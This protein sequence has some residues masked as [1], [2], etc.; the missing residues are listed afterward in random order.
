MIESK[1]MQQGGLVVIGGYYIFHSPM[2]NIISVSIGHTTLN[3]T[4]GKPRAKALTIMIAAARLRI[5]FDDG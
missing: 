4:S 1:E 3:P 5:P 2:S